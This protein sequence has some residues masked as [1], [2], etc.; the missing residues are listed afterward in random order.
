[1]DKFI[2]ENLLL[3]ILPV[4]LLG[5]GV[6]QVFTLGYNAAT[7][8]RESLQKKE[9]VKIKEDELA[10]I[11]Q[12]KEL[13]SKR[14][15][16]LKNGKAIFEVQGQ[17]F[18][19]EASFGSLFENI[20]TNITNSGVRIR[21]IQYNYEPQDDK[22]ILTGMEGYNACELF[23]TAVG[24]YS[25]LQ[26]FFKDLAKENYLTNIHEVYIEPYDQD[27]NILIAKFKIRL[28]TKTI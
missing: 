25:Q 8:Y 14:K 21:M 27:K 15:V 23:F 4:I 26:T 12:N 24:S 6:Y 7:D 20:L 17:Q 11:K 13:K 22:I 10:R 28:Y 1:M 16:E 5:F 18:S 2:K 3:L 9:Q 19:P